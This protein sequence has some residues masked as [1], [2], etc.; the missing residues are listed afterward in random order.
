MTNS[1]E[2]I[3]IDGRQVVISH[4]PVR[5]YDDQEQYVGDGTIDDVITNDQWCRTVHVWLVNPKGEIY[6]QQ[7][8]MQVL[9]SPG[10]WSESSGGYVD[11]DMTELETAVKETHEELGLDIN[12]SL[13]E[14]IGLIRQYEPRFDGRTS[15]QF[16]SVYLVRFDFDP[17]SIRLEKRDVT[18]GQVVHWAKF[19]E[20]L[21]QGVVDFVDHP[22]EIALVL[23]HISQL[24]P[25]A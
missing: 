21:E 18:G 20:Q 2:T 9:T 15:K 7:R 5:M 8:S 16:V 6:L 17:S 24:H 1:E 13:F 22:E 10:K 11:G 12:P 19:K 23:E 25:I 14:K 4:T 3:V